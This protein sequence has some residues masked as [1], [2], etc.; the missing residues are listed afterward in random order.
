VTSDTPLYLDLLKKVLTN[1]IYEGAPFARGQ[2]T[3]YDLRARAEGRD[4]PQVA[5]TMVGLRRLDNVQACV[6]AVLRDGVPGDLIETGVWCGGVCIFMRGI[7]A[8]HGCTDRTVWIADSFQGIPETTAASHAFDQRV[9]LHRANGVLAV[10]LAAVQ[11][12]FAHYGLL[13][14]QVRFLPGWFKDSLPAAPVERLAVLRL[15]G[16]LYESTMV[17]LDH[18]Y[19]K[20]SPGGFVIVDDYCLPGC[21]EAVHEFRARHGIDD[22]IEPIDDAGVYWR[23]AA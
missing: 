22:R 20:L 3:G 19:P 1:V 11:D 8:A 2:A 6:E 4:W 23:R 9:G 7:L 15:D 14:E 16:D 5:R 12:N 10:S 17:A 21:R 18:L 13:D